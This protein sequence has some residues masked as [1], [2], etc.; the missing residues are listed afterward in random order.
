MTKYMQ[1]LCSNVHEFITII[2]IVID[3][4]SSNSRLQN[5]CFHLESMKDCETQTLPNHRQ[6]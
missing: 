5:D 1:G 6:I 4:S 3:G 2:I